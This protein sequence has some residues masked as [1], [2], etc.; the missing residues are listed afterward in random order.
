MRISLQLMV[1]ALLSVWLGTIAAIAPAHA[2]Q[3]VSNVEQAVGSTGQATI[4]PTVSITES[5]ALTV[6]NRLIAAA[7]AASKQKAA[8]PLTS[9]TTITVTTALTAP[10]STD[11]AARGVAA[12]D[13]EQDA[14]YAGV[15][16]GTVVANRTSSAVRFFVEGKTYSLDPLRSLGLSLP[17]PTAVLNLF[18]CDA[19]LGE[20]EEGCFWDPYLLARDGFYEIIAGKDAGALV[21]LILQEAGAP[22]VDQVWIQNRTGRREEIY[23]ANQMI[24]VAP[25]AVQELPVSANGTAQ[26]YMRS[27]IQTDKQTVCEWMPQAAQA[28]VYYAL[29]EEKIVGG[30]AGSTV[31]VIKLK[32]ILADASTPEAAAPVIAAPPQVICRLVV[33]AINVRS[34]PGL[35]FDIVKKIRST[36]TEVATVIA[37]GRDDTGQWL[38]LDERVASGGWITANGDFVTC[39]G[40]IT[41]LPTLAAPAAPTP[42][43]IPPV[44]V[45]QPVVEAPTVGAVADAPVAVA[46]APAAESAPVAVEATPTLTPTSSGAPTGYA[47]L[48]VNNGFDQEMRFTLDQRYRVEVGASEFD[49]GPGQSVS[50]VVFPGS[51]AFS[52]STAWRGLSGN[53]EFVIDADQSRNL[54][55]VFVPDPGE[56]GK[57]I[58]QF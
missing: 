17:R 37:V 45:A 54:W 29:V 9:T 10:A 33:P 4:T 15:V 30:V 49:L 25:A 27:C 53:A 1:A 47:L 7:K 43:A 22:P 21:S 50:I 20:G 8:A 11:A 48:I 18:N 28:G 14:A 13:P 35:G 12:L 16:E 24:E 31:N 5:L 2:H 46:P 56:P 51:I 6:P 41:A 23:Y 3:E 38:A 57:W 55:L 34:G 36:L 42:T 52:A 44:Q 19:T 40:D 39:D 32:S 58:L 26:I